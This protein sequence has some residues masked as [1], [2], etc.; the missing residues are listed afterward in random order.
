MT[1][2]FT[3]SDEGGYIADPVVAYN[4]GLHEY[5]VVWH[6]YKASVANELRVQRVSASGA[7]IGDSI[8]G[9]ARPPESDFGRMQLTV[10]HAASW[11]GQ[12]SASMP[13]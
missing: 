12:A 7:K 4:A 3:V 5:L 10:G 11:P 2:E 13:A 1:D 8:T 9:L 6:R